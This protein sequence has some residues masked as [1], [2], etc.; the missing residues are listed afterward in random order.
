MSLAKMNMFC[1]DSDVNTRIMLSNEPTHITDYS[2]FVFH[3]GDE[4]T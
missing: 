2:V 4:E 3:A 1:P